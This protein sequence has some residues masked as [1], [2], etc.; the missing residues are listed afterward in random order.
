MG[1]S[2]SNHAH[3]ADHDAEEFVSFLEKRSKSSGKPLRGKSSPKSSLDNEIV[4]SHLMQ[5]WRQLIIDSLSKLKENRKWKDAA[6]A[7]LDYVNGLPLDSFVRAV[8]V[9]FQLRNREVMGKQPGYHRSAQQTRN[10]VRSRQASTTRCQAVQERVCEF[11]RTTPTLQHNS[12]ELQR[13]RAE[14]ARRRSCRPHVK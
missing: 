13:R 12:R 14:G 9:L 8:S 11:R 1:N 10:E 4:I 7:L 2:K 5:E 6:I 3:S